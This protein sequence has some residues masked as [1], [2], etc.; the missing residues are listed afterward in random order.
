MLKFKNVVKFHVHIRPIFSCRVT[1]ADDRIIYRIIKS[2]QDHL[3]L[4]Q[5]LHTVYEW[6]QKWKM[7]F[8]ISKCVGLITYRDIK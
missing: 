4:Q 6:S 3:Q 1:F 2:K 8:N 7:R 5:D